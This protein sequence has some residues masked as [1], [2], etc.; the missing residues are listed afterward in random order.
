MSEFLDDLRRSRTAIQ[1]VKFKFR[2]QS[3]KT[4]KD[5]HAFFE[6]TDDK[7]FYWSFLDQK[8]LPNITVFAYVCDG[9]PGVIQSRNFVR[10]IGKTKGTLFFVDKDLDDLWLSPYTD[11]EMTFVTDVYSIENYLC[12]DAV[13]KHILDFHVFLPE[14]DEN[15]PKIVNRLSGVLCDFY[16]HILPLVTW[17]VA[18]RR[19]GQSVLFANHGNN[20]GRCFEI[21]GGSLNPLDN[22]EE[23]FCSICAIDMTIIQAKSLVGVREELL[24]LSPKS[25][26]R[27]KFELWVFLAYVNQ[28]WLSLTGHPSSEKKKI[29]QTV[30]FS[31]DNVFSILYGVVAWPLGLET[32]IED[33][34]KTALS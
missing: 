13:L 10:D 4:K 25:W 6:S 24:A 12:T 30:H 15:Y 31:H 26:S 18:A 9:K 29:K 3:D 19:A 34:V 8:K 11:Y 28:V 7:A 33:R 21:S 16:N 5:I 23:Q 1:T 14:T 17:A 22:H 27:G 32:Y 20:L 2:L